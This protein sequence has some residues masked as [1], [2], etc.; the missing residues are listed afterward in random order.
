[1][2]RTTVKDV[3]T[4]SVVALRP[5]A[6]FG[7]IVRA[8]AARGISGAPVIDEDR[9]VIG[10][11]SEADLLHKEEFTP[12]GEEPRLYVESRRNKSDHAKA[13]ARTARE[14]MSSPAVTVSP[15]ATV[16]EAGRMLAAHGIKRLP[17]VD[18]RGVLVG[19][20]SRADLLTVYL[21]PDEVIAREILTEVVERYLW[22][23]QAQV[24]VGVNG[25]VVTLGGT[26]ERRSQI[27]IAVR[28][29]SAI[30]GVVDVIDELDYVHDDIRA[31]GG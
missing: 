5:G 7:E 29:S 26:V 12:R 27:P 9:H 20:V 10:V 19:I 31:P 15:G 3:M 21:R 1:M 18:E 28:L 11:V 22:S 17:V 24:R 23:D 8:M 14:L 6:A 16:A 30:D 13:A 2:L 4:T 25:G